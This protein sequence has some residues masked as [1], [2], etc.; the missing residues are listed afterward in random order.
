MSDFD[1]NE[2]IFMNLDK[3]LYRVALAARETFIVIRLY[4]L[5]TTIWL[6]PR[7]NIYN[8]VLYFNLCRNNGA[9]RWIV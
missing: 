8:D 4:Y 1:S 9:S 6:H 3:H 5:Q 2:Y 7:G